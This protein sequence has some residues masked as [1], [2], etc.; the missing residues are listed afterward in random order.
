VDGAL[1]WMGVCSPNR[2]LLISG[3]TAVMLGAPFFGRGSGDGLPLQESDYAFLDGGQLDA[4]LRHF[5][6]RH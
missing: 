4:P 3:H 6:T 5:M 1:I 2:T